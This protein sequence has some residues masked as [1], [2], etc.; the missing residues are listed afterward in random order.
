MAGAGA[1]DSEQITLFMGLGSGAGGGVAGIVRPWGALAVS[2][3]WIQ[4]PGALLEFLSLLSAA[5]D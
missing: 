4:G 5:K 2:V 3:L 1:W